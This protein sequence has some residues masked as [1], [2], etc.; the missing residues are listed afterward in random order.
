M[1]LIKPMEPILTPDIIK[2]QAFIHQIK[3]DGIRGITYLNGNELRTFTKKGRERTEFYPELFVIKE[4]LKG[5]HAILDG[6][7]IVLNNEAKPTFEKILTRERVSS[8][9]SLEHYM[10]N[11]QIKYIVFD[12]LAYNGKDLTKAPYKDR[13]NILLDSLS[14]NETIAITDDF[15]NGEKLFALMKEKGW[16]GIVSKNIDSIYYP[17]KHHNSW[18]KAKL[19]RKLLA[20]VGGIQWKDGFPNSLLLGV[21]RNNSFQFIGK[22]SIGL[23]SSDFKLLKDNIAVLEQK[24]SPFSGQL[25]EVK[26]KDITFTKPLLTC[27]VEFL[28]WTSDNALRHPQI[29][30]FSSNKPEEANGKEMI[31]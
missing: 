15:T 4:L 21:Y 10:R 28:E 1:E 5:S 7:I 12:I 20:V 23:K 18:F 25:N 11:Y 24:E 13:R 29:V 22:A 9:K 17:G 8:K 27:W 31:V 16:E 6:E 2:D 14:Q 19:K 3:W 30:G 26:I